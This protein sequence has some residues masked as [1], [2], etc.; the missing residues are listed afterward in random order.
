ML[1]VRGGGRVPRRGSPASSELALALIVFAYAFAGLT[2]FH[3]LPVPGLDG[4]RML[5]LMLPPQAAQV[6]RN[7]DKYLPLF[8]LVLLFLFG[9]AIPSARSPTRLCTLP[10]GACCIP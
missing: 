2:I 8:V 1:D 7:A 4:A 9:T 3:L 5:A 6:Y 10:R